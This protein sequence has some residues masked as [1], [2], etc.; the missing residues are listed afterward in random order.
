MFSEAVARALDEAIDGRSAALYAL[1]A[2]GSRLPGPRPNDALAM[3]FAQVCRSRG[4][5]ADRVAIA[6]SRLSVDEAPGATPLE[7]LPVCG[8]VAIGARAAGDVG[9]RELLLAELHARADDLRFRVRGAVVR[10]LGLV[11][12]AAGDDLIAATAAWMD[13]YFHAAAVVEALSR[14]PWL[15]KVK[16]ASLALRCLDEAFDLARRAPRAASRYPGRK[17]LVEALARLA[18]ALAIRFGPPVF[19]GLVRWTRPED[20]ELEGVLS[21]VLADPRLVSRF[22]ED[23]ERVRRSIDAARPP[24]RN[25]DHDVGPTRDRSKRARLGRRRR[26]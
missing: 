22:S 6:M 14:E 23:V 10:A 8:V 4:A 18:V 13:G 3:A 16:D 26:A 2:R 15:P 5:R 17:A 24:P 20:P 1:L 25:P 19:G 12:G 7:F 21:A 11:G 9:S